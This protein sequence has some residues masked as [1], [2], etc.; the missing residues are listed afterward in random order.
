MQIT[1]RQ[2]I[3]AKVTANK[4][5][6]AVCR[7]IAIVQPA[8]SKS[9]STVKAMTTDATTRIMCV[10]QWALYNSA[11]QHICTYVQRM[12]LSQLRFTIQLVVF[13]LN[14]SM[15]VY[16]MVL[17]IHIQDSTTILGKADASSFRILAKVAT[18]ITSYLKII[19][20]SSAPESYA[21]LENL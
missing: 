21:V 12:V 5:A 4:L 7:F 17:E 6:I 3:I 9:Q 15:L 10:Q 13:Q 14:I 16:L 19:A 8:L 2:K 20:K 1:S 11:A 18:L